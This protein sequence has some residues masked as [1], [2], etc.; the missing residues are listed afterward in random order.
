MFD[1]VDQHVE[2]DDPHSWKDYLTRAAVA[3]VIVALL[4]VGIYLSVAGKV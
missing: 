4:A 2:Q 3:L 1:T